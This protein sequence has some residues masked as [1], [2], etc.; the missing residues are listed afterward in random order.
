MPCLLSYKQSFLSQA[1]KIIFISRYNEPSACFYECL[2]NKY[3][4]DECLPDE[5][6]PDECLPIGSSIVCWF[7]GLSG[8][9]VR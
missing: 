8:G 7:D 5:Y 6:L 3:L 1:L 2:P 9:L 4:P